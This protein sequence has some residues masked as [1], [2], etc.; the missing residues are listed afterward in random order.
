MKNLFFFALVFFVASATSFGKPSKSNHNSLPSA[1]VRFSNNVSG[2]FDERNRPVYVTGRFGKFLV[3]QETGASVS[4]TEI[5]TKLHVIQAHGITPDGRTIVYETDDPTYRIVAENLETGDITT[6]GEKFGA[7]LIVVSPV[8]NEAVALTIEDQNGETIHRLMYVNFDTGE[9]RILVDKSIA[10]PVI[11]SANGDKLFL[12]EQRKATRPEVDAATDVNLGTTDTLFLTPISVTVST[13]STAEVSSRKNVPA[14]FP[15]IN[16]IMTEEELAAIPARRTDSENAADMFALTNGDTFY[17]PSGRMKV[18]NQGE[19][20]L[21]KVIVIDA[22]SGADSHLSAADHGQLLRV[23]NTGIIIWTTRDGATS[24]QLVDWSNN[25]TTLAASAAVTY[26]LP[27]K[28]SVV[29]QVGEGY[30]P[31]YCPSPPVSHKDK[32][33][34][35][36]DFASSTQAHVLASAKGKVVFASTASNMVRCARSSTC[37]SNSDPYSPTCGGSTWGNYVIIRHDDGQRTLYAHLTSDSIQVSLNQEVCAGKYIG[38]QGH[39]GSVISKNS[40]GDHLHHQLMAA[41]DSSPSSSDQ[42]IYL[43][44]ADAS[45]PLRCSTSYPSGS[46]EVTSCS[47]TQ[48]VATPSINPGSLSSSGPVTASISTATSGA[49]IRYTYNGSD[50]TSSSPVYSGSLTF[51]SSVTLKAKAFKSG[52]IDSNVASATYS[53]VLKVA[54]PSINPGSLSSLGP[55]TASISTATS[56]ATIRYTYNGADPTSSSAVYTGALTFSSSVT[57]K[58]KAFKSGMTDSDIGS[59]SYSILLNPYV[60]SFSYSPNPA[61]A[62][63]VVSLNIYGGNF[64]SGS[65]QVWFVG[66]GCSSPGCQTSAVSVGGSSYI[67]AQAVLNITGTYTVNI[68][69]GGG[70]WVRVG[71]VTVVK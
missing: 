44:Y 39:T 45:N 46:T 9:E 67:G 60:N 55:V 57:L 64:V 22:K 56:G 62:T 65:T 13:G 38:N 43:A 40:C 53:I 18:T 2:R 29:T 17:S 4:V 31:Y 20:E 49:T 61:K 50:P 27:L 16:R 41:N 5:K 58:A 28:Q 26:N 12:N 69:N 19:R 68:R 52:M 42:T 7:D 15:F 37:N 24:I 63:R 36:Y 14:V 11:W 71:T 10:G 3:L 30:S 51:N 70:S 32:L 1:T 47:T 66:P 48:S 23:M 8:R 6:I 35:A 33:K 25:V 21:N 59:A 54:T 34:Y